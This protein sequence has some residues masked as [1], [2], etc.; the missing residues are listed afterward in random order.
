[1]P[2]GAINYYYFFFLIKTRPMLFIVK[3]VG[4]LRCHAAYPQKSNFE[5]THEFHGCLKL[6]DFSQEWG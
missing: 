5:T 1:M 4:A 2:K 3:V 6:A